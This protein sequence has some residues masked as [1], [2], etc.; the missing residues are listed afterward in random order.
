MAEW[1]PF[2]REKAE[3]HRITVFAEYEQQIAAAALRLRE[4][5]KELED[6][7]RDA[8]IKKGVAIGEA[9]EEAYRNAMAPGPPGGGVSTGT[10]SA[11]AAAVMFQ[12]QATDIDKKIER[13]TK[14]TAT[15]M[16]Y[17]LRRVKYPTPLQ[18][19]WEFE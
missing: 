4:L 7:N 16:E 15:Y 18:T 8:E 13:N 2:M 6:L 1:I 12:G 5:Q 10:F 3:A 9:E 17:Y 19:T 14:R 11:A